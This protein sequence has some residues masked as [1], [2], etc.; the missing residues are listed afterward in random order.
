MTYTKISTPNYN[1]KV[2]QILSQLNITDIYRQYFN[3]LK[4]KGNKYWGLCPFH[5]DHKPTNFVIYPDKRYHCFACGA[6]G[7]AL[8]LLAHFRGLTNEEL[9]RE[10]GSGI[11]MDK[12]LPLD[13]EIKRIR[14]NEKKKY[15]NS[16]LQ[17]YQHLKKQIEIRN[18]RGL[19]DEYYHKIVQEAAL[20]EEEIDGYG[21]A[22]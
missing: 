13:M 18:R 15:I 6:D 21:G 19:I 4:Q 2:G 16:V 7:D 1:T 14:E 9:I 8:N 11:D 12:P 20:L 3:E 10:L 22:K 17:A 5:K